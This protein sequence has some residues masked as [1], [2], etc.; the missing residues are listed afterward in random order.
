MNPTGGEAKLLGTDAENMDAS[1]YEKIG[2][3]SDNSG[4]YEKMF[5]NCN[6]SRRI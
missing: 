6:C 5:M 4:I 1:I 2:V 3:V